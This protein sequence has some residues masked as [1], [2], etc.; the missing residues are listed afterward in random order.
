MK[1]TTI[2]IYIWTGKNRYKLGCEAGWFSGS[3]FKLF[4]LE[5]MTVSD[6]SF[7]TIFSIKIAKLSFTIFGYK[8]ED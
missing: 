2:E 7:V 3:E 4:G 5:F 1:H 6:D 8:V